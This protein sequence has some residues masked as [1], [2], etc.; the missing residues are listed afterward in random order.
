MK[1]PTIA[2]ALGRDYLPTTEEDRGDVVF[3][4]RSY[5]HDTPASELVY[6]PTGSPEDNLDDIISSRRYYR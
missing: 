3:D 6:V 5:T 1:L 2:D 4:T